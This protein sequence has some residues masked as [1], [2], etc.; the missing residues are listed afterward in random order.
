MRDCEHCAFNGKKGCTSWDCT[1]VSRNNLHK[2][3]KIIQCCEVVQDGKQDK[4]V[5]EIG[6]IV[7]YE[8]IRD[9][10]KGEKE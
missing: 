5:K 9:L 8:H 2:V 10:V 1:F 6:K 3:L 4:R 7:A